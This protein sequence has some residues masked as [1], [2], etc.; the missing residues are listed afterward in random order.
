MIET[1]I[2][3]CLDLS[4]QYKEG[5]IWGLERLSALQIIQESVQ[6]VLSELH[7]IEEDEAEE[8]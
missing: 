7:H 1:T 3:S 4:E 2:R 6:S 5:S 8:D